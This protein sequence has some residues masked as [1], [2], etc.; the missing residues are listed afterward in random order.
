MELGDLAFAG[1]EVVVL[2]ENRLMFSGLLHMCLQ[3]LRATCP[4]T[5]G[6][7][8][9]TCSNTEGHIWATC[10]N[11]EGHMGATCSNTEAT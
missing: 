7:M 2:Q 11:T 1:L 4:N 8:R 5:E 10:S 3:A 9:A 6:H